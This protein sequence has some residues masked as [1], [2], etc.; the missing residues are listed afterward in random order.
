VETN[1]VRPD[2]QAAIALD[3]ALNPIASAAASPQVNVRVG[4]TV[5]NLGIPLPHL[6]GWTL[7]D[8]GRRL[9]QPTPS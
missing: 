5:G 4:L 8:G 2:E 9:A 6:D 7:A 3:E 1:V